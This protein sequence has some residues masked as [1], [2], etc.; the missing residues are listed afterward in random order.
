MRLVGFFVVFAAGTLAGWTA[1][2][3][4][5]FAASKG[6]LAVGHG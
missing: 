4:A 2:I 5:A 3:V 1:C 6:D